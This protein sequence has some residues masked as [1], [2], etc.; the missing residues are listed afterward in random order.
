VEVIEEKSG[1]LVYLL[2]P[3]GGSFRPHVFAPGK[4]TVRVSEPESGRTR[5]LNGLEASA[6]SAPV[7]EVSL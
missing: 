7:L 2:R 5:S 3:K 1:E 6:G 4:Y